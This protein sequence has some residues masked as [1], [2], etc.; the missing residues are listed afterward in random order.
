MKVHQN[1]SILAYS[2]S[3]VVAG[4]FVL[5]TGLFSVPANATIGNPAIRACQQKN[6]IVE[7]I[8]VSYPKTDQFVFCKFGM[9][10]IAGETLARLQGGAR[11]YAVTVYFQEDWVGGFGCEHTG[12]SV[13]QGRTLENQLFNFCEYSDGSKIEE[14]TLYHGPQ[15]PSNFMLN[16]ALEN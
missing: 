9:A 2:F 4:L 8:N 10:S 1:V 13:V 12:G 11:P 3:T 14:S 5:S 15:D 6:G 16:H 7:L